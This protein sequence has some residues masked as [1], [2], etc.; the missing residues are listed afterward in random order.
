[1]AAS[2]SNI[3]SSSLLNEELM[4]KVGVVAV[5]DLIDWFDTKVAN[6]FSSSPK[7]QIAPKN[8]V[9]GLEIITSF[10]ESFFKVGKSNE[11]KLEKRDILKEENTKEVTDVKLNYRRKIYSVVLSRKIEEIAQV[12]KF[13]KYLCFIYVYFLAIFT[14]LL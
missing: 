5:V 11:K 1:M 2:V 9:L 13:Q 7:P 12:C 14:M 10:A 3:V 8:P 6:L 4:A